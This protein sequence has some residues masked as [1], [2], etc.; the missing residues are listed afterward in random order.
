MRTGKQN[1]WL[2]WVLPALAA[3]LLI[4]LWSAAKQAFAV[5]SYLLPSP[6]E[7]M[8]A[9]WN[10]RA[11]L[12]PAAVTTFSGAL[13]GFA[14]AGTVGFATAVGLA[15]SRWARSAVYPLV[16][17]LQMIPVI[18]LAPIIVIWFGQGLQSVSLIAFLITFFPVV[19][20]TTQGM[21]S[22]DRNQ[23]DLFRMCGATR[24]QELRLLRIPGAMPY[25]LTGLQIAA[26][27][28][29]IGAIAGEF[30]AGSAAGGR[31]GGLGFLVIVYNAQVKTPALF[32]TGFTACFAGFLFVGATLLA[33]WLILRRWHESARPL[34]E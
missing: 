31:S 18:V 29:M 32:A 25:F 34:E 7:V 5:P 16:L 22:A 2:A 24:W 1:D 8:R 33:R 20:N 30:F 27:L 13:I 23:L 14:A 3:A 11:A 9:A 15:S 12:W 19:A 21:L 6:G 28:A 17:V 26:S 4:G 10:E